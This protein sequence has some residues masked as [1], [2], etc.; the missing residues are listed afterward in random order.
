MIQ[1]VEAHD[2]IP[3]NIKQD[4]FVIPYNI[5]NHTSNSDDNIPTANEVGTIATSFISKFI[6]IPIETDTTVE[7]PPLIP[8]NY[9]DECIPRRTF[10]YFSGLFIIMIVIVCFKRSN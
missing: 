4:S 2:S 9:I 6:A 7:Q 10:A 5:S 3:V 8:E 1:F